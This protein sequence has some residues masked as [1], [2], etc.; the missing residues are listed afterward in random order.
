MPAI[1][2]LGEAAHLILVPAV[3]TQDDVGSRCSL[4]EGAGWEGLHRLSRFL[5]CAN[6]RTMSYARMRGVLVRRL[7]PSARRNCRS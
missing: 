6:R 5:N 2:G 7:A 1:D 3:C 4:G